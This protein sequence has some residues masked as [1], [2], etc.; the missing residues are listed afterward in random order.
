M[1]RETGQIVRIH[2]DHV[3]VRMEPRASDAHRCGH[4]GLCSR[5]DD[6]AMVLDMPVTRQQKADL[7]KGQQVQVELDMPSPY[8]AIALLLVLPLVGLV[9]GGVLGQR[10]V[11]LAEMV[12]LP[13]AVVSVL[14]AV[15]GG[16][17][18][19]GIGIGLERS[20]ASRRRPP[21]LIT[22]RADRSQPG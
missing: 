14:L 6:G 22:T 10:W 2:L 8:R 4:C 3:E 17:V 13:S 9:L 5:R 19:L 1:T 15:L 7:R 21:R 18:L 11:A 20:A 12:N 16:G